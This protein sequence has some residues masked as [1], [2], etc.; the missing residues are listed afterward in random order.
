MSD[1]TT[2]PTDLRHVRG[3]RGET[4]AA[5]Y[6]EER[7]WAILD[8][9]VEAPMGELDLV[10]S[11]VE[12]LGPREIRTVAFVEVKARR[13]TRLP[14]ELNIT[15]AKR[16]TLIQL[17]KWYDMTRDLGPA[18]LRF[19][20]VAVFLQDDPPTIEHYPAAFDVLGRLN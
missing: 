3:A 12:R 17:G 9:N 13:G 1:D 11:R 5:R 14:P 7:D 8:R 4:L 2:S 20:V 16:Q 10:I 18:S 6:L 19:D 15:P